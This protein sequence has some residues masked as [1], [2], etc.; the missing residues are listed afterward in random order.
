MST[1]I[2]VHVAWNDDHGNPDTLMMVEFGDDCELCAIETSVLDGD[3]VHV[4][5]C[6]FV[7]FFDELWRERRFGKRFRFER[8]LRHVG[9]IMWD[10]IYM[11]PEQCGRFAVHMQRQK[12]WSLNVAADEFWHHW[13]G[14][15]GEHFVEILTHLGGE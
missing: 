3:P 7:L 2:P 8:R 13:G 14:L 1:L 4:A 15:S 6:A 5:E 10:T 11:T 9:N 12:H